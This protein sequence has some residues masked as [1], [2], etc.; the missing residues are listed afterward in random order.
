MTYLVELADRATN[1]LVVLYAEKNAAE[2]TTAARWF[3]GLEEAVYSLAANPRRCPLAPETKRT[4]KTLRHLLYGKKLH[5]YRVIYEINE[6]KK[7]VR[8]LTIRHGAMQPT[9]FSE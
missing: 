6:P 7:L 8:V 3:N 2:S 5:V 9:E 4:R 1:D